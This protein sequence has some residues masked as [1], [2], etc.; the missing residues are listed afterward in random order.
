MTSRYQALRRYYDRTESRLGYRLLLGGTKHFGWY[1]PG[2]SPW[3]FAAAMRRMEDVL[4]GRL[5]LPA[6][7]RVLDAGCGEGVVA[8]RLVSRYG[9][10]VVGV[11]LLERNVA[12]AR[13]R[14]VAV[15]RG[16]YHR[17]GLAGGSF[18]GA[19]TMETLV[20]SPEPERALGEL[21]RVL[22]PGGR[23][24]LVEY[25]RAPGERLGADAEDALRTVCELAAMPGWWRLYHG[26]LERLLVR[27][28]FTVESVLDATEH[29][30]PM[31]RAFAALGRLPYFLGRLAGQADRV[32]NALSAVEMYR[33][34]NVWRYMIY[35]AVRAG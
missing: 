18:D 15:V 8:D 33:H 6:G 11:D 29:M 22:R 23:L 4:V 35:T 5:A 10:R 13:R 26:E 34:R 14:P 30:L 31:L 32:V 20:H 27:A 2:D 12:R 7:A 25:S 3:R 1:E 19:Y 17:L 21:A 28:G 24:V 9:L 16:D